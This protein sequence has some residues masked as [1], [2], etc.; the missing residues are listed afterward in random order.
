MSDQDEMV[1]EWRRAAEYHEPK[2]GEGI[3]TSPDGKWKFDPVLNRF[4]SNQDLTWEF[5]PKPTVQERVDAKRAE[6]R[7]F[8]TGATRDADDGKYDYEGFLSPAVLQRYAQYMH[9]N[10]VQSDGSLRS[11]DNW[12]KGIPFDVYM[13]SMWRHFMDVWTMHRRSG[14]EE[15]WESITA[16]DEVALEEALCAVLFNAQGYLH[17]LLREQA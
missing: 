5:P 3:Y 16:D 10:R 1:A 2:S 12:Q 7:E 17:E 11:G 6:V 14:E 13:K 15:A 8:A 4:I 9:A